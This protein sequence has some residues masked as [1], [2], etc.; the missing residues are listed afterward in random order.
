AYPCKLPS[1]S[2]YSKSWLLQSFLFHLQEQDSHRKTAI[3]PAARRTIAKEWRY[4]TDPNL[5]SWAAPDFRYRESPD[6]DVWEYERVLRRT[7]RHQSQS[8]S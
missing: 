7:Q 6:E 1:C 3:T 5:S 8:Q 2:D 4:T